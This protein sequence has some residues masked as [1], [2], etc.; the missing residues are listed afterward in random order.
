MI[1]QTDALIQ[2]T[3]PIPSRLNLMF[4][5]TTLSEKGKNLFIVTFVTILMIYLTIAALLY[6]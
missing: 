6:L 1:K 2:Q 5:P 4:W 3:K